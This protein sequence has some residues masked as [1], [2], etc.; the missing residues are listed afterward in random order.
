MDV[1][2]SDNLRRLICRAGFLLLCLLPTLLTARWILFPVTGSQWATRIHQHLG[3]QAQ[4]A[5]ISTPTPQRTEFGPITLGEP[6][7]PWCVRID[8]AVLDNGT[9]GR[10]LQLGTVTGSAA[11]VARTLRLIDRRT[12]AAWHSDRPLLVQIDRILLHRSGQDDSGHGELTA[13]SM[14]IERP[15]DRWHAEFVWASATRPPATCSVRRTRDTEQTSWQIECSEP[16]MP[17]WVVGAFCPLLEIAGLETLVAGRASL[18]QRVT[19]WSGEISDLQLSGVDL[20]H[21]VYRRFGQPLT[22]RANIRIP[23]AS[24]VENRLTRISGDVHA[25][26]GIVGAGFLH[27]C[28][29]FAGMT[30]VAPWGDTDVPY[31]QLRF[32]FRIHDF[33]LALFAPA[34]NDC[35]VTAT[36]GSKVLIPRSGHPFPVTS[37]LGIL[38]G[39]RSQLAPLNRNTAALAGWLAWPILPLQDPFSVQQM[40]DEQPRQVGDR[41]FR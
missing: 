18:F 7:G 12:D 5:H 9:A 24:I 36:D 33:Q 8:T 27:A 39:P 10:V 14:Q 22:G 11:A 21:L 20:T 19:G 26:S 35:M 2:L 28:Q 30:I 25:W 17:G 31:S 41:V 37:L 23:E 32:G 15:G 3:I 1:K 6:D 40:A 38:A 16:G 13:V 34:D 29:K 4:V